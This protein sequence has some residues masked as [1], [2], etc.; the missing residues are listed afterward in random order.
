MVSVITM[1]RVETTKPR[2]VKSIARVNDEANGRR[3]R[4][5]NPRLGRGV[6]V[7]LMRLRRRRQLPDIRIGSCSESET[8]R[9][10]GDSNGAELLSH[11]QFPLLFSAL[12][13]SACP[14]VAKN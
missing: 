5:V 3:W 13:P 11:N 10:N 1:V 4:V 6:V 14:E 2:P 12:N 7:R 9:R 8:E